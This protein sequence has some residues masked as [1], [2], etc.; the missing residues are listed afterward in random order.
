MADSTSRSR[1]AT[2][3]MSAIVARASAGRTRS[4]PPESR[5]WIFSTLLSRIRLTS[6]CA[7]I[8]PAPATPAT[9]AVAAATPSAVPRSNAAAIQP[10]ASTANQPAKNTAT[11]A[12]PNGM[13]RLRR[14]GGSRNAIGAAAGGSVGV[15]RSVCSV[16]KTCGAG[17][18][19]GGG[20]SRSTSTT[21]GRSGALRNGEGSLI[22]DGLRVEIR[23]RGRD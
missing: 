10:A 1:G 8:A 5:R 22:A 9:T 2:A 6:S 7:M 3:R 21:R 4:S 18:A 20:V 15:T 13:T 12:S 23:P 19:R 17:S 16:T 14:R 11:P